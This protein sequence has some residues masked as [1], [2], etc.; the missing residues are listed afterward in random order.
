LAP[1]AH[2]PMHPDVEIRTFPVQ[3]LA[4]TASFNLDFTDGLKIPY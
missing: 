4:L 2:S 3:P 1:L